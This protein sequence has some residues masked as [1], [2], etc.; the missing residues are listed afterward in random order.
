MA[1]W[2]VDGTNRRNVCPSNF[3]FEAT[4]C[5]LSASQKKTNLVNDETLTVD[6]PK[7]R[8]LEKRKLTLHEAQRLSPALQGVDLI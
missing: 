3:T 6:M 2:L 4:H 8:N 5:Y 7:T 1:G